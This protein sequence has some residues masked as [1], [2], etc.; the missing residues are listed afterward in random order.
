M[1]NIIFGNGLNIE[2][3]DKRYFN[4]EI[5]KRALKKIKYNR[6]HSGIYAKE[7]GAYIKLLFEFASELF[8]GEKDYLA[9]TSYEKRVLP[10]FKNRSQ[11]AI[12]QKKFE[13]ISLEDYFFLHELF[14]RDKDIGNPEKFYFYEFM[15]RLFLDSIYDDGK[16]NNIHKHFPCKFISWVKEFDQIFTTNYDSNIELSTGK[17]VYHLHGSF[18]VLSDV[19][20]KNSLRNIL[21][22]DD[23]DFIE[24]YNHLY[25]NAIFDFSGFG[26]DFKGNMANRANSA[27]EKFADVYENN[28]LLNE[29][30]T[31]ELLKNSSNELERNFHK[32]I[33]HKVQ[34]PDDEFQ[35]YYNFD[36]FCSIS[37]ELVFLGLSPNNDSHILDMVKENKNLNRIIY[38][39]FSKSESDI[40]K[41]SFDDIEIITKNVKEFWKCF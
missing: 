40:F 19:Y 12:K 15:K 20:D 1:R 22:L 6:F 29:R 28:E 5:L 25:C 10:A 30:E 38:Y 14:C 33:L 37:G 3:S 21:K 17:D 35:D 31:I 13:F 32:A 36:R 4:H 39:Y 34:N 23:Y 41:N 16:L 18:E 26:K 2:F 8:G 11:F 27:F 9:V 24:G 7:I